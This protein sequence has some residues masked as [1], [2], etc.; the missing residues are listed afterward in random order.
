MSNYL[1]LAFA[2][3]FSSKSFVQMDKFDEALSFGLKALELAEKT[4]SIVAK[5]VVYSILTRIFTKLEDLKNSKEYF[6]KLL[7]LPQE[8]LAHPYVRGTLTKAVF[9]AGKDQW[10]K[11][12]QYFNECFEMFK[13]LGST[14]H[15]NIAETRLFYAWALEK[16]GRFE[17]AKIQLEANQKIRVEIEQEFEHAHVMTNLM[18]RHQVVVGEELEVRLDLVNVAKNPGTLIRVEGLVPHGCKVVSMPSFCN[19]KNNSIDMN[20]KKLEHFQVETIKL[21]LVFAEA[22]VYKLEPCVFYVDDMGEVQKDKIEPVTVTSQLD[23][24]VTKLEMVVDP[25]QNKFAFE[26]EAAEKAFNF[27]VIAFKEDYTIRRLPLDKSGWRTL[28]EI[29]RNAQITTFSLYGRSGRGGKATSEL[30][31]CDVVESRFFLGERGRGGRVLKMRISYEKE[32]VKQQS[33]RQKDRR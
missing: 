27:L 1:H 9:Y 11:S 22:G 26:S 21:R 15:G 2:N 23:S 20:Q 30:G 4:D 7:K 31:R 14:A 32:K 10:E 17:E 18:V 33:E 24:S 19:L 16:Q 3:A 25:L 5:G 13:T 12:N 8:I 29:A 28:M 6:E